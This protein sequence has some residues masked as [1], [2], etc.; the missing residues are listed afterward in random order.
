[1]RLILDFETLQIDFVH[2]DEMLDVKEARRNKL[3]RVLRHS[4]RFE[5]LCDELRRRSEHCCCRF[6][7]LLPSEIV[8]IRLTRRRIEKERKKERPG[9]CFVVMEC[10]SLNSG[11]LPPRTS[12]NLRKSSKK[13]SEY[14]VICPKSSNSSIFH[15]CCEILE[16]SFCCLFVCLFVCLHRSKQNVR[17]SHNRF[18]FSLSLVLSVDD[19]EKEKVEGGRV[20][21]ERESV[22][23]G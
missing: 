5:K 1:M 13:S 10:V 22:L 21:N 9:G 6:V 18:S 7:V 4:N 11:S 12:I 3:V 17:S 2:P 14:S 8:S 19:N 20:G 15:V 16:E 23:R